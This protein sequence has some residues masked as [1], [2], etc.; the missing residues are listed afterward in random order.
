MTDE[1]VLS[2]LAV[3]G[4]GQNM[5]MRLQPQGEHPGT[6]RFPMPVELADGSYMAVIFSFGQASDDAMED[7]KP[8]WHAVEGP[9]TLE[10]LKELGRDL[11]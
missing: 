6:R 2:A 1:E 5:V 11:T 3:Y 4:G 9:M 7:W 10:Q 8:A